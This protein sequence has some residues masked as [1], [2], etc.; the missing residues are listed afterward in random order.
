MTSP[1][2]VPILFVHHR[3]ELGG[4]PESLAYLIRRLDRAR[5]EPHVFVPEGPAAE[6]FRTAGAEIHPGTVAAFTH[7]WA[8]T[9][10][11][12]R[13]LLLV[14][15]LS[16]LPAH[17]Y[18]LRTTIRHVRPAIV[19]LNDSPALPAAWL[20]RRMGLPVVWHLR[21]ALPER[22]GRRRTQFV[23]KAVERLASVSI[24]I[25]ED[26]AA[27]F[28]AGSL[29]IPNSVDLDRFRPGDAERARQ[30]L[31]LPADR[32]VVSSFGFLYPS[33]GFRQLI[34]AARLVRD[35]HIEATYLLVGGD[36]RGERYFRTPFGRL[37]RL[38]RV[39]H[40]FEAEA[41]DLVRQL[42][43]DGIV[44]VVAYRDDVA[45]LYRA[46]DLVVAP[47]QGPELGRSLVEA[48]ASGVAVVASGSRTGGGIVVPEQTGVLSS[49]SA[50]GIAAAVAALLSDSDR[51]S[52]LGR[53]AREH[54]ESRFDPGRNAREI[55]RLYDELL[56]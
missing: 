31:D 15:E 35:R 21:A 48:A 4:A 29:V 24:A 9:Y 34:A 6:L 53:A 40:N 36:I 28:A 30:E 11:G 49:S 42:R 26:V 7:I 17:T 23:R 16:R 1:R 41:G 50:D 38:L 12:P 20:A 19:H 3:R 2:P 54:A 25:N 13:W 45:E 51:R 33:K 39:S 43:L 44:R 55:E 56:S 46:S 27:S 47:S 52:L 5:F 32:P 22:D 10:R 18:G 8:S 37:L 14:R